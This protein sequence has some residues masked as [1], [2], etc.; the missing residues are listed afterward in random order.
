MQGYIHSIL[1]FVEWLEHYCLIVD[2]VT[3]AIPKGFVRVPSLDEK[4]RMNYG[5]FA[6]EYQ[7][8]YCTCQNVR[9]TCIHPW[10]ESIVS[11]TH[12]YTSLVDFAKLFHYQMLPNPIYQNLTQS[13]MYVIGFVWQNI[14]FVSITCML[15][16][17][18]WDWS[19]CKPMT[20]QCADFN[21]LS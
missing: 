5:L 14:W 10:V 18:R 16:K 19:W 3:A 8:K 12:K 7:N 17:S 15:G 6:E 2:G 13:C 20:H 11:Y 9:F 4:K 21:V 1:R